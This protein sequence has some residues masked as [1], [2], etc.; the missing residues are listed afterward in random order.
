MARKA[1]PPEFRCRVVEFVGGG[2]KVDEVAVN[3]GISEQSTYIWRRQARI[4]AGAEPGLTSPE[5]A[6]LVAARRRI[7]E[8]E[9]EVV[10]HR[11][12]TG[13]PKDETSPRDGS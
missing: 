7:R 1:Y 8:L 9:I 5:K 13:L 11:R 6:E 12:A 3:L 2:R 10:I 4:D